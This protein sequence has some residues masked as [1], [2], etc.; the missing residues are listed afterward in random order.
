MADDSKGDVGLFDGSML[1]ALAD[2]VQSP[3]PDFSSTPSSSHSSDQQHGGHH[4]QGLSEQCMVAPLPESHNSHQERPLTLD[5]GDVMPPPPQQMHSSVLGKRPGE[6]MMPAVLPPMQRPKPSESS[7]VMQNRSPPR[8]GVLMHSAPL[9][10]PDL[11]DIPNLPRVVSEREQGALYI[12][13]K[14]RIRY[15]TGKRLLCEH[16]KRQEVCVICGGSSMCEH[17][18]EKSKCKECGGSSICVHKRVRSRCRECG[19][20]SICVHNAIRSQCKECGGGSLCSHS[21][22]RSLCRECGGAAFCQHDRVKSKCKICRGASVCEHNRQKYHCKICKGSAICI[23]DK[24][25]YQCKICAAASAAKKE[26]EA[27]LSAAVNRPDPLEESVL[28]PHEIP[29][30]FAQ[31]FPHLDG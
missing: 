27:A 20:A 29:S 9:G 25:K 31:N 19:G 26:A 13:S 8:V 3:A 11:R 17:G 16:K 18:R 15:W 28:P 12:D 10:M 6:D 30:G 24:I 14:G 21:R 4:H 2:P 7:Q 1:G 5:H 22:K 23:H